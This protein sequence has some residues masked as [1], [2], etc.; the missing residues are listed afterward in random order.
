[1]CMLSVLMCVWCV[2]CAI[3]CLCVCVCVQEKLRKKKYL[4]PRSEAMAREQ[5]GAKAAAREVKARA[6]SAREAGQGRYAFACVLRPAAGWG[7]RLQ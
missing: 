2:C 6:A 7:N 4:F 1:M 5:A 3:V